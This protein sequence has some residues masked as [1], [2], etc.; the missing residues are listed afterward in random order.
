[1][2][3]EVQMAVGSES[4]LTPRSRIYVSTRDHWFA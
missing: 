2:L 1:M 4:E 3:W